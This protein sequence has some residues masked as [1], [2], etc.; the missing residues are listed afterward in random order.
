MKKSTVFAL[1]PVTA[2]GEDPGH[3]NGLRVSLKEYVVLGSELVPKEA[4]STAKTRS[5]YIDY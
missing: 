5:N 2:D 3:Q 4:R 1:Y